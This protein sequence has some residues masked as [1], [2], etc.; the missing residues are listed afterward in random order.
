[1]NSKPDAAIKSKVIPCNMQQASGQALAESQKKVDRVE[2]TLVGSTASRQA[3][4][5]I[6]M[7][8]TG[9]GAFKDYVRDKEELAGR[10]S[11]RSGDDRWQGTVLRV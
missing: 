2:Q 1:M 8:K 3:D 10:G 6:T 4:G 7:T 5:S 11:R 9:G